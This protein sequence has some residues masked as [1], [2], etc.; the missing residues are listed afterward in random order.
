MKRRKSG[1]KDE[2]AHYVHKRGG[3]I[4]RQ[5]LEVAQALIE[6]KGHLGIGALGDTLKTRFPSISKATLYRTMKLLCDAGIAKACEFGEGFLRYEALHPEEHHDH[7]ICTG[8][9]RI[10]EFE[11]KAIEA[12]QE[13]VAKRFKFKIVSHR[14]DIFGLCDKCRKL[15]NKDDTPKE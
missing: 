14:L 13:T 4:T 10:V 5:R 2:L 15:E 8:C 11:E 7:L 6:E 1:W 9:G 3:R 12:L